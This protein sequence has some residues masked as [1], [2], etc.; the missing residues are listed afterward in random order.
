MEK[1][2]I[3]FFCKGIESVGDPTY[4]ER[5]SGSKA[6]ELEDVNLTK[7]IESILNEAGADDILDQIETQDI[8]KHLTDRGYVVHDEDFCDATHNSYSAN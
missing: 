6:V 1:S 3:T 8:I 7:A 5:N 2:N 4:S